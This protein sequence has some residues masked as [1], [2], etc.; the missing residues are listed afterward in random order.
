MTLSGLCIRIYSS[1]RRVFK[2]LPC[3]GEVARSAETEGFSAELELFFPS[4]TST[5][6]IT[7]SVGQADHSSLKRR[8]A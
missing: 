6:P 3:E 7:T 4:M 8:R 2:L 1:R 5:T